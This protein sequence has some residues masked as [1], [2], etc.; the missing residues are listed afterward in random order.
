MRPKLSS[1]AELYT[2]LLCKFKDFERCSLRGPT[3]T[4]FSSEHESYILYSCGILCNC[5]KKKKKKN[6]H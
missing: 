2:K 6:L 3:V 4:S 5:K 1:L